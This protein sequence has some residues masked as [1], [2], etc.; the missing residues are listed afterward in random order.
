MSQLSQLCHSNVLFQW[1]PHH[2]DS[3]G[4][5]GLRLPR[6]HRGGAVRGDHGEAGRVSHQCGILTQHR[7][8]TDY[9]AFAVLI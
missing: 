7:A 6:A 3:P 9:D 1:Y 5:P 2:E 8:F 4:H